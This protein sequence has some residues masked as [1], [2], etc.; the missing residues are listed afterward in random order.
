M[1]KHAFAQPLAAGKID[2]E[3]GVISGVSLATIGPAVGHDVMCDAVTL[4]QLMECAQKYRGGLKVKMA[5]QGDA[6][7]IIGSIK[8]LRME[9]EKLLGDLHLLKSTPYRAYVLEIASSIPDTFG[10]SVA[11]SGPKQ[12]VDGVACAR[13]TEIYSCDMVTEPAA[14]PSGLFSAGASEGV[15]ANANGNSPMTPE[16]IKTQV[17]TAVDAAL[18]E[19][20][21]RVKAV[22]DAIGSATKPAE[23]AALKTQI[24]ELSAKIDTAKTEFAALVGDENKRMELAARVVA[25]EFTRHTGNTR[26]PAD[27]GG[28]GGTCGGSKEPTA[29]AKFISAVQQKF[30]ATKS[31]GQALQLAIAAEPAGYQAFRASGKNITWAA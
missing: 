19:F 22:E 24:T 20:S 7:D 21:A 15:D 12:M 4:R 27:G 10:L 11:F 6:G 17:K 18:Q 31:K 3:A 9:G 23:F 5:H 14:N 29:E 25:Q 28:N 1:P 13:C 2:A 16:D 8:N 26:V 30:A